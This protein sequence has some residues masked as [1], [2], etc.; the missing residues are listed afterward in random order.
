L[1]GGVRYHDVFLMSLDGHTANRI[2]CESR[3]ESLE[4]IP[5]GSI[6]L[7]PNRRPAVV[8]RKPGEMDGIVELRDDGLGR[9]RQNLDGAPTGRPSRITTARTSPCGKFVLAG[10]RYNGRAILFDR[11]SGRVIAETPV[12]RDRLT[13]VAYSPDGKA[14]AIA[15]LN[16]RIEYFHLRNDANGNPSING[17]PLVIDAH[18]GEAMSV[19]FV[20]AAKLASCGDDGFVRIWS[21]PDISSR[22]FHFSDARRVGLELSPD[23]SELL[24]FTRDEFSIAKTDGGETMFRCND[25]AAGF[26]GNSAWSPRGDKVAVCREAPTL[27][28]YDRNGQSLCSISHGDW[29]QDVA[30]SSNGSLVAV[31][32]NTSLQICSSDN[33]REVFRKSLSERGFSVA[34]SH[35]GAQLAYGHE[36]GKI[37]FLDVLEM[38]PLPELASGSDVD[39]MVFGPDD[40]L[41]ATGHGDSI[42]RLW[43]VAARKLRA[44]LVGHERKVH[45]LAF[46]P[47]GRTLLSA[48][49]DGSIRLWSVDHAR[50]YGV[51]CRYFKPGSPDASCHLSL[52]TDGRLLAVGYRTDQKDFPD[53]LL[54]K[55]E[56]SRSN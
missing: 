19:K 24:Y 2:P 44:E 12:S 28:V 37:G 49:A 26:R 27:I 55:M 22:S 9:V 11:T 13:D 45:D 17:P 5:G 1:A 48:S 16:G 8:A 47:D 36:S 51:L 15:Y 20:D 38:R 31:I 35:D 4:F 33:G 6:L 53:V 21:L 46:S 34:F 25:C 41:L 56:P 10:E 7:V 52:S 50:A 43:D 18:Q 32:S 3:V 54:W 30:F 40:S 14:I 42:I 23:G 39:C 29:A